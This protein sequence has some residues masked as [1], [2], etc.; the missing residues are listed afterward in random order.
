MSD[1]V[2]SIRKGFLILL[3]VLDEK[4]RAI[5]YSQPTLMGGEKE[6]VE[7]VSCLAHAH[8]SKHRGLIA[9]VQLNP[10][11]IIHSDTSSLV[12]FDSCCNGKSEREKERVHNAREH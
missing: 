12:V 9:F 3:P 4:G 1:R 2:E 6:I 7:E 10:I 5:I 11:L 8:M